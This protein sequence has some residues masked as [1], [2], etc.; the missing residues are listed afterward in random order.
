MNQFKMPKNLMG[1]TQIFKVERSDAIIGEAHGFFCGK[2]YP[3]TIQLVENTDIK[4]S[5]WLIDSITGQRYHVIDARPIMADGEP[6]DWMV[7]YQTEQQYASSITDSHNT[8]FNI[9][10]VNG[11]SVIGNQNNVALNTGFSLSDIEHLI[12]SLPDSDQA[13]ANELLEEL[14]RTE[15]ANHPVLVE[16]ALSKFSEL[17]KK[18]SDMLTAVGS[19]AVKL[20]IGD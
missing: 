2:D 20:L 16:G 15:S 7:R 1:M 3:S 6:I 13:E 8:V 4:N 10:S 19:W 12:H 9:Q 17:I 14:R 18:H 11:T 5:D